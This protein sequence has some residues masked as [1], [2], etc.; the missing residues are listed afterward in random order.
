M[1]AL[2]YHVYLKTVYK[3][4]MFVAFINLEQKAKMQHRLVRQP[5]LYALI[6]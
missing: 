6:C 5:I 4:D 1:D 2:K 3:V